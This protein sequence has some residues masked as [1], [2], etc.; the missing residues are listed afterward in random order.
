MYLY[1]YCIYI[2]LFS[3]LSFNI[4]M[5]SSTSKEMFKNSSG[6]L[7]GIVGLDLVCDGVIIAVVPRGSSKHPELP[8]KCT[9]CSGKIVFFPR[10][11]KFLPSLPHQH[12]VA[13]C[14]QKLA[15]K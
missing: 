9:G 4:T 12:W 1:L 6:L 14:V 15:S 13:I 2:F 8:S 3:V 7:P 10:I 11:F 5:S